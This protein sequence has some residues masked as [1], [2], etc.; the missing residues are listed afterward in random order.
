[1]N[2][3]IKIKPYIVPD[4]QGYGYANAIYWNVLNLYKDCEETIVYCSLFNISVEQVLDENGNLV[5]VTFHSPSLMNFEMSLNKTLL[6]SWGP[7]VVI[8]DYVLSYDPNFQRE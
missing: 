2:N 4:D 1:M 8:D 3:Y 7:D 5:D 6:D